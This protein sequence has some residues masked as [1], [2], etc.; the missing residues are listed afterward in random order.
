M[1]KALSSMATIHTDR[2]H[3]RS[4]TS[5][6]YDVDQLK[7]D[8]ISVKQQMGLTS[9]HSHP[10]LSDT[11]LKGHIDDSVEQLNSKIENVKQQI[12]QT[13]GHTHPNMSDTNLDGHIA[14]SDNN[15][16][17][18][19]VNTLDNVYIRCINKLNFTLSL[20]TEKESEIK[21]AGEYASVVRPIFEKIWTDNDVSID[22]YI[23]IPTIEQLDRTSNKLEYVYFWEPNSIKDNQ[24]QW[25]DDPLL[26]NQRYDA[27]IYN[28]LTELR[29]KY[30]E[31]SI[32]YII[33]WYKWSDSV[34]VVFNICIPDIL[35]S[36]GPWIR[37]L[38]G[39]NITPYFPSITS[40][41]LLPQTYKTYL[42][43]LQE[44]YQQI[45]VETN[46]QLSS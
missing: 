5:I 44:I 28:E 39:V 15:F 8:M 13:T 25:N 10:N 34:K 11:D 32:F 38:S 14:V 45:L 42:E 27:S 21:S 23:V 22:G 4:N 30:P 3:H 7:S 31:Q 16:S 33:N 6:G 29:E 17:I 37:L 1:V 35:N 26:N 46:N 41:D 24:R 12:E 2:S 36:D 40:T 20:I 43:K 9:E 19:N 18:D